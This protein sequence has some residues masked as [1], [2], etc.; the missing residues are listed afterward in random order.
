VLT[1]AKAAEN[2]EQD[3]MGSDM[4]SV[5]TENERFQRH[6]IILK[7]I[8]KDAKIDRVTA[9]NTTNKCVGEKAYLEAK[10]ITAVLANYTDSVTPVLPESNIKLSDLPVWIVTYHGITLNKPG[11]FT[12]MA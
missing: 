2:F 12:M 7:K 5:L 4:L 10:S 11:L 3:N 8:D 9:I 6:G 1:E